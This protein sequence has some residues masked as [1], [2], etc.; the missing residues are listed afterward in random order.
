MMNSKTIRDYQK[1]LVDGKGRLV[2]KFDSS[3]SP[4]NAK[5]QDAI[6]RY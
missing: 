5:I 6:H 3:V 1:Y 2:A 4:L